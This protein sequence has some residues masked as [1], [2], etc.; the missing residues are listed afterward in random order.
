MRDAER[1]AARRRAKV[2]DH[3]SSGDGGVPDDER[4]GRILHEEQ[5]PG[6]RVEFRQRDAVSELD[7]VGHQRC[8]MRRH[9]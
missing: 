2:G 7:G 4:G 3:G 8:R 1:L 6:E 5:A 9:A